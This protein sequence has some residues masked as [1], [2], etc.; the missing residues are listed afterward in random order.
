MSMCSDIIIST[1]NEFNDNSKTKMWS[2]NFMVTLHFLRLLFSDTN[3]VNNPHAN[4]P[5]ITAI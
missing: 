2:E 4:L 1:K 3:I 5:L